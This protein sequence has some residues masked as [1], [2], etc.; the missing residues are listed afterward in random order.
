VDDDRDAAVQI[1]E[2][3]SLPVLHIIHVE[4]G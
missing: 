4:K 1:T 2:D 3:H